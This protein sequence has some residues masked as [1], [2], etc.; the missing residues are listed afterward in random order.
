[1]RTASAI[2]SERRRPLPALSGWETSWRQD[3]APKPSPRSRAART[4]AI[5]TSLTARV[6]AISRPDAER[7]SSSGGSASSAPAAR[8]A[9]TPRSVMNQTRW[10]RWPGARAARPSRSRPTSSRWARRTRLAGRCI[11]RTWAAVRTRCWAR[12][13]STS[14]HGAPPSNG[15]GSPRA[16]PP[17]SVA[18]R[19]VLLA[20]VG[21]PRRAL[22]EHGED[23][24][25]ERLQMLERLGDGAP[26]TGLGDRL[27]RG[28]RGRPGRPRPG[29]PRPGPRPGRRAARARRRSV[30]CAMKR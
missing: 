2:S 24:L 7:S 10:A 28:R 13:A 18:Q 15:S 20:A 22:E 6:C 30:A 3:S 1:M 11:A 17:S 29:H 12:E 16:Q 8:T 25:V 5:P 4:K 27:A 14:T 19:L 26:A 9:S 23:A 21:A